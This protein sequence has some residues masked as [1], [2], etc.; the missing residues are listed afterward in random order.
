MTMM[1]RNTACQVGGNPVYNA[2]C[3][4]PLRL[5][6]LDPLPRRLELPALVDTA[7]RPRPDRSTWLA[8]VCLDECTMDLCGGYWIQQNSWITLHFFPSTWGLSDGG[9]TVCLKNMKKQSSQCA[10]KLRRGVSFRYF[11]SCVPL[12]M[13]IVRMTM[14]IET[15]FQ[16][17]QSTSVPHLSQAGPCYSFALQRFL[18]LI[19]HPLVSCFLVLSIVRFT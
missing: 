17:R 12:W 2:R 10:V 6:R 1:T 19:Y 11:P 7:P 4:F 9:A 16:G 14:H 18:L 15:D 3:R 5:S 8:S 13:L